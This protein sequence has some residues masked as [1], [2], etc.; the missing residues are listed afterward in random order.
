VFGETRRVDRNRVTKATLAGQ[1]I[2]LAPNAAARPAKHQAGL[3]RVR[4]PFSNVS[5]ARGR[6]ATPALEFAQPATRLLPLKCAVL[7]PG[8]PKD[9]CHNVFGKSG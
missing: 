4:R 6:A 7:L 5:F 9:P 2:A 3:R 1:G 8:I